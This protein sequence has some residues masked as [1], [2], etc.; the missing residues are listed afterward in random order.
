[1]NNLARL[2]L[3]V[4]LS[5]CVGT[6]GGQQSTP[7]S[8]GGTPVGTGGAVGSA[9]SV[10]T[11]G[12]TPSGGPSPVGLPCDVQ[13]M[14]AQRCTACHRSPP[15]AGVPMPLVSYADLTAPSKS[16]SAMTNAE[17]AVARMQA[18]VAPMPP[19]PAS[20][21][22]PGEIATLQSWISAGYPQSGCGTT[23]ADAGPPPTVPDPFTQPPT[24][25]SGV[26][27]SGR[28]SATMNPGKACIACHSSDEGPSLTLAGT[29]YPTAHEPDLCYG[30]DGAN[31]A[32][33]V[34]AGADGATV[35]L[36]PNQTGNFLYE[37]R[38]ALP[39]R[40]KVVF[41][42]RERVMSAAQTS[43]DC[44]A[45][46]TQTGAMNAPGRILLP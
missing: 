8:G 11:S 41:M 2:L 46:H 19:A 7:G 18:T 31:G 24:C 34:I 10:G 28:K 9:G 22:T 43:G 39:Y 20:P 45:C 33:V 37:G 21:A 14:L 5:G 38:V 6:I 27:W 26:T 23:T 3:V 30:A 32:M 25:T 15:L 1:M 12:A 40:A 36:T 29:V 4:F 35:T 16:N 44:N 42:G 17:L 13:A